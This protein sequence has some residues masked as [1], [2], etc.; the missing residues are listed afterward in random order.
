MV[1]PLAQTCLD[2]QKTLFGVHAQVSSGRGNF[3]D[4]IRPYTI[5]PF[6]VKMIPGV[7]PMLPDGAV[8]LTGARTM[9]FIFGR[10]PRSRHSEVPCM[11]WNRTRM[12]ASPSIVRSGVTLS[13]GST[14]PTTWVMCHAPF[15]C[16]R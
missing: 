8:A 16:T 6:F 5:C 3:E 10:R 4:C 14:V 12:P 2:L 15:C 11:S 9:A 7:I 1:S 13:A